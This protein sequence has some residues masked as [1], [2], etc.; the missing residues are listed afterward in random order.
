M[1]SAIC[2]NMDQSTILS[3]GPTNEETM[4]VATL[5][6]QCTKNVHSL[7][8]KVALKLCKKSSENGKVLRSNCLKFAKNYTLR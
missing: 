3:S 8:D 1:S 4:L 5:K 6:S 7:K 2:F